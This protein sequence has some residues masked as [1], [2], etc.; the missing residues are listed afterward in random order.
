MS[1]EGRFRELAQS[2]KAYPRRRAA[3]QVLRRFVAK[4]GDAPALV[5]CLDRLQPGVVRAP[6]E[7]WDRIAKHRTRAS[8]ALERGAVALLELYDS[9][10]ESP[11]WKAVNLAQY[12]TEEA[13]RASGGTRRRREEFREQLRDVLRF[14][15]KDYGLKSR[16]GGPPRRKLATRRG[17][18][19]I[20]RERFG[21]SRDDARALLAVLK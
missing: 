7:A 6:R 12:P 9:P 8:K 5:A 11:E 19:H 10:R 3:L 17:P 15:R 21:I 4:G 13:A 14:V 16:L 20:L 1:W 18:E 2:P